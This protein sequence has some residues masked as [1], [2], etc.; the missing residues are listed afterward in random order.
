VVLVRSWALCKA[1]PLRLVEPWACQQGRSPSTL[2]QAS[3]WPRPQ[4]VHR[5]LGESWRGWRGA[6]RGG[7]T[8][9]RIEGTGHHRYE[10][11]RPEHQCNH[12]VTPLYIISILTQLQFS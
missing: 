10:C 2:G 1:S 3:L 8:G 11:R 9:T 4:M 12:S 5:L 6:H 7:R